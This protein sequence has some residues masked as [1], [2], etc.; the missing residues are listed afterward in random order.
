MK[1]ELIAALGKVKGKVAKDA[2][3]KSLKAADARIRKAC[4]DALGKL[5]PD[6][7]LATTFK[8]MLGKGDPSYAVEG[9][10]LAAYARQNPKDAAAVITPW[11]SKES[12]QDTLAT[13]ALAAMGATEDPAVL[14][15]LLNWTK[16]DKPR[17]RRH[18]ALRSLT[19]LTKS[20]RLNDDRRKEIVK[21]F[22]AA[23]ESDDQLSRVAA[24][25]ALPDLGA[26]ASSALPLLDKMA[27]EESRS[28]MIRM[29][30]G[31]ADRI[32]AQSAGNTSEA[33]ELN[34]LRDQIKRLERSQD[35]L[36]KRLEKFE[37]GKN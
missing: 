17:E 2:L 28:G 10:M 31:A 4:I 9:A 3:L 20:K 27:H 26:Q 13:A 16:P 18:G 25:R 35:E 23:L 30:K 7:E 33:N 36:K 15:T 29:I 11:L 14:D 37:N 32:R 24:L 12:H 6:A 19:E 22:V 8:D 34:Q 1:L 5:G 21:T